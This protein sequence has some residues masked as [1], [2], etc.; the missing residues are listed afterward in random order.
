[1]MNQLLLKSVKGRK[2]L[3]VQKLTCRLIHYE[4][5]TRNWDFNKTTNRNKLDNLEDDHSE[6]YSTNSIPYIDQRN[7]DDVKRYYGT[8][9]VYGGPDLEELQEVLEN[10]EYNTDVNFINEIKSQILE[11][12]I[13][14][15][16]IEQ[17]M[18]P[19]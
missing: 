3:S 5:R 11:E 15:Y 12:N 2:A 7:I 10:P 14:D 17:Y 18:T 4:K 19:K 16:E 8:P 13:I 9:S 1:M 6:L